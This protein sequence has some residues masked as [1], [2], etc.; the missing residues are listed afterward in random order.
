MQLHLTIFLQSARDSAH[1]HSKLSLFT[2][3]RYASAVYLLSRRVCMPVHLSVTTRSSTKRLD[4]GSRKQGDTI[5]GI[6]SCFSA[7]GRSSDCSV[8]LLAWLC[9][10]FYP[11]FQSLLFMHP[12]SFGPSSYCLRGVVA[13]AQGRT[14]HTLRKI[15]AQQMSLLY[16][17]GGLT[18][19]TEVPDLPFNIHSL[20][21]RSSRSENQLCMLLSGLWAIIRANL[22]LSPAEI[23]FVYLEP[24]NAIGG[25]RLQHVLYH[26]ISLIMC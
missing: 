24:Q 18:P 26:R 22:I 13:T 5:A 14:F 23:V 6:F 3:R 16:A 1:A 15:S 21:R 7:Q 9:P 4:V 2:A 17:N 8:V 11:G 10:H 20:L 19:S 25:K 12:P